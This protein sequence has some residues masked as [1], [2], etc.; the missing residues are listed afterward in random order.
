MAALFTGAAIAQTENDEP[1][2]IEK[3]FKSSFRLKDSTTLV[4]EWFPAEGYYLY[5][6]KFKFTAVSKDVE[7]GTPLI[8]PGIKKKDPLFGEVETFRKQVVIEVPFKLSTPATQK[9]EIDVLSQGCADLG[10]CYPP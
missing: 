5:R 8:P 1:L 7:L 4:A 3:A 10:L 6:D 2:E 9:I